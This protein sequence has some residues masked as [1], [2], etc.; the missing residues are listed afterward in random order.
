MT[1]PERATSPL[2][3]E[4]AQAQQHLLVKAYLHAQIAGEAAPRCESAVSDLQAL[5]SLRAWRQ[6]NGT[7][8]RGIRAM[9]WLGIALPA[10]DWAAAWNAAPSSLRGGVGSSQ[11]RGRCGTRTNAR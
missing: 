1:N 3:A 7:N 6:H 2:L 5:F 10:F 9:Q 8:H 4:P 11:R